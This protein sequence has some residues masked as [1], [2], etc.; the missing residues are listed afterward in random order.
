M[1]KC[2]VVQPNDCNVTQTFSSQ[3]SCQA[4]VKN[5]QKENKKKFP[6]IHTIAHYIYTRKHTHSLSFITV[7]IIIKKR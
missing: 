3:R 7:I 6:Y 5:E 1:F 2:L 4:Q